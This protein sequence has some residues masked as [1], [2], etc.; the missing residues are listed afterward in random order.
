MQVRRK[1]STVGRL[2]KPFSDLQL[3]RTVSSRAPEVHPPK[4]VKW[5]VAAA[6]GLIGLTA[7][8]A[9]VSEL[10]RRSEGSRR[11]P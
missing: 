2:V 3:P 9:A 11:R 1:R 10:R 6:G 4:A 7:G 8:S 5:G